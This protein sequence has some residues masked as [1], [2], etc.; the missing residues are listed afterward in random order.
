MD[1]KDLSIAGLMCLGQIIYSGLSDAID[2]DTINKETLKELLK[3]YES[4]VIIS[5]NCLKEKFDKVR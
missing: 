3:W 4:N 2:N 5:Y 1:T